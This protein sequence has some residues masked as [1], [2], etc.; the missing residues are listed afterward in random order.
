M[1][2]FGA[3]AGPKIVIS[4]PILNY[5]NRNIPKSNKK[6]KKKK[7]KMASPLFY[8]AKVIQNFYIISKGNVNN[9]IKLKQKGINY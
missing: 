4:A 3:F 5:Y 7:K 8:T 9:K 2:D 6:K 1:L